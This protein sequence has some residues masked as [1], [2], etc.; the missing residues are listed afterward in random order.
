M[1]MPVPQKPLFWLASL[2][3]F[4]YSFIAVAKS[5][6]GRGNPSNLTA[7]P[8]APC[9]FLCLRPRAPVTCAMVSWLL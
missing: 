7:T 3:R 5:T 1:M 4:R 8:D 9:V 6:A 2:R